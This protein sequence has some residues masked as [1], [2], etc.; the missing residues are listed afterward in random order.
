MYE[1]MDPDQLEDLLH[2]MN[3]EGLNPV[4]VGVDAY[5]RPFLVY[6]WAPGGDGW[7]V[8]VVTDDTHSRDFR[9]RGIPQCSECSAHGRRT[10]EVLCFPVK[11]LAVTTS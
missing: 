2:E 11:V 5:A 6:G 1:E 7:E 4:A 3:N 8:G 9:Y 10:T